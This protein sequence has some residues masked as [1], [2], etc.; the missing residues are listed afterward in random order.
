MKIT[1]IGTPLFGRIVLDGLI[2]NGITPSLVLTVPD[3]KSGRGRKLSPSPVK[4]LAKDKGIS[5]KEIKGKKSLIQILEEEK[6]DIATVAAFGM[7]IDKQALNIPL[8]GFLNV[9]PSLLPKYRGASP[10]QSAI[11]DGIEESGVTIIKM[12]ERMDHGPIIGSSKIRLKKDINYTEAEEI[13]AKEGAG[14]L[15]SLIVPFMKGEVKEKPQNHQI[16]TYTPKVLKEHGKINWRESAETIERK[17][18]AF[19]SWPGTFTSSKMGVIKILEAGIQKQTKDGPFGDPG[20]TYLATNN[21][22][23]VQTGKDFLI[24]KRLQI[25]GKRPV[26]SKD[27]LQG[28]IEFIGSILG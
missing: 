7:I 5:V 23:A 16:A 26:S 3:K 13:L 14:L 6:P 10:I 18:R 28:N 17:V 8:K 4:Q 2:K 11:I 24:I 27:F 12:D 20:K 15:S 21:N 22:I 1:F 25:E 19:I 9:H